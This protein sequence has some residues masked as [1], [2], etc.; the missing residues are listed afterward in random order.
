MGQIELP[1]DNAKVAQD[2]PSFEVELKA[3][4]ALNALRLKCLELALIG[5]SAN[6]VADLVTHRAN[7]FVTY[8]LTGPPGQKLLGEPDTVAFLAPGVTLDDA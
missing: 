2:K 3:G 8:V 4:D 1:D 5:S 7:E 6:V